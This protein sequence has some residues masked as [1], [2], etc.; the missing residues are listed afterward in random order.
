LSSPGSR[1]D[2]R[3]IPSALPAVI[4]R[5]LNPSRIIVALKSP[6]RV[7]DLPEDLLP[8]AWSQVARAS[9]QGDEHP[10]VGPGAL[11][12]QCEHLP[13]GLGLQDRQV[14]CLGKPPGRWGEGAK[15][16]E[17]EARGEGQGQGDRDDIT[18]Y[19]INRERGHHGDGHRWLPPLIEQSP[20]RAGVDTCASALLLLTE[21]AADCIVEV[22]TW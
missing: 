13:R 15:A 7:L 6:L 14:Y 16:V 20:R 5:S 1:L 10:T 17:G 3:T 18:V 21:V 19:K 4:S 12:G 22:R 8:L 2:L 9:S 11:L